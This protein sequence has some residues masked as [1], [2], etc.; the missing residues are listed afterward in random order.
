[1]TEQSKF[2]AEVTEL[3]GSVAKFDD[4]KLYPGKRALKITHPGAWTTAPY[5]TPLVETKLPIIGSYDI[6]GV[7]ITL[8]ETTVKGTTTETDGLITEWEKPAVA[9]SAD[10][11]VESLGDDATFTVYLFAGDQ[12]PDAP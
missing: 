7:Q 11:P 9:Y 1:M 4:P 6:D 10:G 12:Q 2:T 8:A 3:P 5:D